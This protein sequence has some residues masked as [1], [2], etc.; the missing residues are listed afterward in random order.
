MSPCPFP[1]ITITPQAPPQ[2]CVYMK[3]YR[4]GE[5]KQCLQKV[6]LFI[7]LFELLFQINHI[8]PDEGQKTEAFYVDK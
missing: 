8:R 6:I 2:F 3:M 4:D 5:K 1:T 7:E